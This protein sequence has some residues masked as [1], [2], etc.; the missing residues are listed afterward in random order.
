MRKSEGITAK[1][2]RAA[3]G[4]LDWSQETLAE[5]SGISAT[6][7]RKIESGCISPRIATTGGIQKA[8]EDAGIDFT[9]QNGVKEH[10]EEMLCYQGVEEAKHFYDDV[11]Q[12]V[13]DA[14]SGI[15]FVCRNPNDMPLLVGHEFWD[16]HI[17]RMA[18]I[19]AIAPV[20]C[21]ITENMETLPSTAY[22]EYRTIP[23]AYVDSVPFYV[24]DD[25]YALIL[26]QAK[27][28][29][30]IVVFQ[31]KVVADAFRNQFNSMWDKA[32]PIK[33]G[34]VA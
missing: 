19:K 1:Q 8:L 4:L 28:S 18:A 25:K 7:I 23:K 33:T 22:C 6:T 13:M 5:K 14:K 24:Y 15:V 27:P 16:R 32:T 29:P 21:I 17:E 3:R 31:S 10:P 20:K 2:I 11:Y 30:K 26:S 9:E 34:T 12:A